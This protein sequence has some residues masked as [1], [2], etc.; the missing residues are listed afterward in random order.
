MRWTP[1][2]AVAFAIAACGGGGQSEEDRVATAVRD[3]V[4]AFGERDARR[5]CA[6]LFPSTNLPPALARK[7][8]APPGQP[9]TPSTWERESRRCAR[10]FDR[11]GEYDQ[12]AGGVDVKD[13]KLGAAVTGADGITRTA[14]V[15][16]RLRKAK[17]GSKA[18]RL[19]LVEFRGDWKVV[20]AIN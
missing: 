13:V 12:A 7:I 6:K 14:S 9:G 5:F 4:K 16:A 2:I 17:P 19:E 8:G 3:Y 18:Q 20:A 11:H 15:M 1:L 10:G